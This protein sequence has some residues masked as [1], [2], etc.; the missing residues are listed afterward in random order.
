VSSRWPRLADIAQIS[1]AVVGALKRIIYNLLRLV[2]DRGEQVCRS[3]SKGNVDQG[4]RR[5]AQS[6]TLVIGGK[7]RVDTRGRSV[8]ALRERA[9]H[10]TL[11]LTARL[12]K[13]SPFSDRDELMGR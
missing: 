3:S 11:T 10:V 5:E 12:K 2:P 1:N 8:T 7:Q 9:L 4:G 13:F 6:E